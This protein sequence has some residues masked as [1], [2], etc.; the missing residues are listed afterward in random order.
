LGHTG[1]QAEADDVDIEI[2]PLRGWLPAGELEASDGEVLLD[3]RRISGAARAA[4]IGLEL[5]RLPFFSNPVWLVRL[6][7]PGG[8]EAVAGYGLWSRHGLFPLDGTSAPVHDAR[9][10]EGLA[11]T[12]DNVLFYAVWFCRFVHGD[13]GPFWV[14][15]HP[16]DLNDGGPKRPDAGGSRPPEV[17]ILEPVVTRR[18]DG[19]GW[20]LT[21][22]VQ[23]GEAL[24]KA[25]F[26]VPPDGV[27]EMVEDEPLTAGL[28]FDPA[29]N[30]KPLDWRVVDSGIQLA[31]HP[32]AAPRH[33]N[34]RSVGRSVG[35]AMVRLQLLQALRAGDA[36][37]LFE[38]KATDDDE[39]LREFASFVVDSAAL[40]VI[41]SRMDYVERIVGDL[42]VT[43]LRRPMTVKQ[44][45]Y[46]LV[47]E[48]GVQLPSIADG[49]LV[50]ISLH[51]SSRVRRPQAVAFVLGSTDAATLVGCR[52]RA[53]MPEPLRQIADLTVSLR[54]I[55]AGMFRELFC[56]V[57]DCPWPT[58]HDLGAGEWLRYLEPMDLQRALRDRAFR[59]GMP[60][61]GSAG[62]R[63][64]DALAAIEART[65]ERLV[66]FLPNEPR[67]LDELVGLGE[68]RQIVQDVMADF[69][70]ALNGR[71]RWDEV[72]RGMLLV[73]PPGTGK[74]MLARV[75]AQE[76][77]FRFVSARIGGWMTGDANLGAVIVAMRQTFTDARQYAP[78]ILFLD[79]IDSLGNRQTFGD[80][81]SAWDTAFLTAVLAELQGF[82]D[83]RGIF[84]IGATNHEE[85]VDPA[86][87][88]AGR[89]DQVVRLDYPPAPDLAR[90]LEQYLAPYQAAGRLDRSLDISA[91]GT[92]MAGASGAEVEQYVRDAARRARRENGPIATRHLVAAATGVPRR[93]VAS[94]ANSPAELERTAYHEAGHAI[95]R[96]TCPLSAGEI[97]VVS[98]VQRNDGSL[99][100]TGFLPGDVTGWS[101][102]HYREY[103][104]ILLAG[105]AAEELRY[106]PDDVSAGAGGLTDSCDLAVA[107][108]VATRMLCGAGLGSPRRL[109][110][111]AQPTAVADVAQIRGVLDAGY[112]GSL[113]RLR[114]HWPLVQ[115]LVERLLVSKQVLGSEVRA[116]AG[117]RGLGA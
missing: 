29:R 43:R 33:P 107:T 24:F 52:S 78:C 115:A 111:R 60:A 25:T 40:V 45:L 42:L 37:P 70:D 17:Y 71:V 108:G 27:I 58:S 26:N 83:S 11:L 10:R 77:G 69:L 81:N 22:S 104:E 16:D 59:E 103:I 114:D 41:E 91:V 68:A 20:S 36:A 73:G 88:R 85:H 49:D 74:T 57:F 19:P 15:L 66:R 13:E 89:L 93:T 65:V 79:E 46:S 51:E 92:V 55:D 82:D 64:E 34:Q 35:E 75:L 100:F 116:L 6:L 32:P 76:C 97:S 95:V 109:S 12:D 80:H 113:Q 72:D 30:E 112:A 67:R 2:N 61:G 1:A 31:G 5:L 63:P 53:D 117:S 3:F 7:P 96:V 56:D 21:L 54:A 14:V 48:P 62:W 94:I 18:A 86:L 101:A 84:V 98:I 28:A 47:P 44:A 87:R 4:E 90:I 23:Y 9:E 99:G 105:R 38:P 110:W 39:L 50:Q 102:A 8:S 106:G